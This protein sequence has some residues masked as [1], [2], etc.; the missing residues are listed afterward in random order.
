QTE[1]TLVA[2][3]GTNFFLSVLDGTNSI[4]QQWEIPSRAACLACHTP[5]AGHALSFN[6]RE[7]NQV[8]NMNG[9]VGNQLT[10]LSDASYFTAPVANPHLLP[11]FARATDASASLEFRVRS[12]FAVNCVQCHQAGGAG[13][14]SWD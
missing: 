12:Y 6:T 13:P 9:V 3:G 10:T 1:A 5:V 8:A 14:A 7:L 2:D 11:A 4:Q